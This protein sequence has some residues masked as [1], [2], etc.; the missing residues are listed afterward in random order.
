M[1]DAVDISA[2]E[3]FVATCIYVPRML[4][5]VAAVP[6][7][8]AWLLNLF[9]GDP[10][11]PL[12]VATWRAGVVR[13]PLAALIYY[14][15]QWIYWRFLHSRRRTLAWLAAAG[16]ALPMVVAWLHKL[17]YYGG[18]WAA[19]GSA[20]WTHEFVPRRSDAM[21]RSAFMLGVDDFVV[22]TTPYRT[23]GLAPTMQHWRMGALLTAQLA[24]YA[25]V[26]YCALRLFMRVRAGIY[27][28]A[29]RRRTTASG[30]T[31]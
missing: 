21:V 23:T 17:A 15:L 22:G 7:A 3:L 30:G 31:S 6:L 12:S 28:T 19:T 5:Y 24:V 9:W 4:L 27:D 14:P 13:L 18:R 2:R 25:G 11:A 16:G 26:V 1:D 10:L 29:R 8:A 20:D